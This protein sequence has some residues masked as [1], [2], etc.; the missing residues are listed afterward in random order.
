MAA[1]ICGLFFCSCASPGVKRLGQPMASSPLSGDWASP[2]RLTSGTRS[3]LREKGLVSLYRKDPA[4]AI[5]KLRERLT[6]EGS[7]DE[8]LAVAELCSDTGNHLAEQEPRAAVGYHLAAAELAFETA[9]DVAGSDKTNAPLAE[10]YNHSVGKVAEI[11]FDSGH[12]WNES[13]T[14]DGPW[15]SYRLRCRN[16][17]DSRF[18]PEG[19]DS[20]EL[21]D[22]I[23]L[24]HYEMERIRRDGIGA[25]MIAH[26]QGTPERRKKNPFLSPIGMTVPVNALIDFRS[27]GG[28]ADLHLTDLLLKD[29]TLIRGRRFPM[30]SDLTLPLAVQVDYDVDRKAGFKAMTHP[31]DYLEH[32]GLYLLEPFRPDQIPVVM[33][34]GLMSSPEVWVEAINQLRSD[35]VLGHRYQLMVYRYPTG[36]P[37]IYNA[38]ALRKQLA[39][40]H[41]KYDPHRRNPNM[42]RMLVMGHSM[43]GILSNSQVRES[44]D[45]FT[46][47]LFTRPIDQL[48]GL[49]EVQKA[50]LKDLLIYDA[51]PDITRAIF[52]AAPHRGA[53]LATGG[54]G[55]LGHKL[56]MFPREAIMARPLPEIDG[57][58]EL[59]RSIVVH[60]PDSIGSLKP[61]SPVLEAILENPV[62]EGIPVHTIVGRKNPEQSLEESDDKTVAYISAHLDEAASEKVVHA[63][64]TTICQHPEAIEEMRRILYLHAGLGAPR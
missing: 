15:K 16:V 62:H 22:Y 45:S 40:F 49:D 58:T 14:F 28:E 20:F 63:T 30:A 29:E 25:A 35:P 32:T 47:R 19:F 33:V 60:R 31:D 41:E 52:V 5:A 6:S 18:D 37:V 13:A 11:L 46:G 54:I 48:D 24:K 64:H 21:A 55:A 56:I 53:K 4:A 8:R 23:E 2:K 12:S 27:G 9:L 43:G 26:R 39:A 42:R 1:L 59:A 61:N 7:T 57:M 50:A 51:N 17:G 3:I 38:A 44:G 36:Y 34:H 10:A